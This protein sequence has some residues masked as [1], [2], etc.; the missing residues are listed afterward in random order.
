MVGVKQ[1]HTPCSAFERVSSYAV[2]NL[3]GRMHWF[4]GDGAEHAAGR[5]RLLSFHPQE[6]HSESRTVGFTGERYGASTRT[7]FCPLARREESLTFGFA[8]IALPPLDSVIC[9]YR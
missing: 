4:R 6:V 2:S 9:T 8:I 5:P 3:T 7:R 1:P